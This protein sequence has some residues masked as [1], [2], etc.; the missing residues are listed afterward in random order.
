MTFPTRQT[1]TLTRANILTPGYGAIEDAK[2]LTVITGHDWEWNPKKRQRM[3][4]RIAQL[5]TT[6]EE[7]A[8]V[9][10]SPPVR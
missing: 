2:L 6:H 4:Q 8:R 10:T 1:N 9:E 5:R 7:L 3:L